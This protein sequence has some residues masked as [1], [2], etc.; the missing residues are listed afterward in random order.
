MQASNT[1]E[2]ITE[3]CICFKSNKYFRI[4]RLIAYHGQIT[5]T[6]SLSK[7]KHVNF[8]QTVGFISDG[9]PS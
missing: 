5:G 7:T 9:D 2:C 6:G 3:I 8:P 1:G 4:Y